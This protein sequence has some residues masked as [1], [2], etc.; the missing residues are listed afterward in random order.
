MFYIYIYRT[1][2]QY[3]PRIV[4]HFSSLSYLLDSA[5]SVQKMINPD[6]FSNADKNHGTRA[7]IDS[8]ATQLLSC[9]SAA[10]AAVRDKFLYA[11]PRE[12]IFQQ[13]LIACQQHTEPTLRRSLHSRLRGE[14][15]DRSTNLRWVNNVNRRF[16][17]RQM[18]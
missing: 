12:A 7:I 17:Q 13:D 10:R 1:I 8:S 6:R 3:Y 2:E 18:V 14:A 11:L 4:I 5:T 15:W 16:C 9:L